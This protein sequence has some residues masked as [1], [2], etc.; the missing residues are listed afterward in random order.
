MKTQRNKYV[1]ALGAALLL[2]TASFT[3]NALPS[4][5]LDIVDGYYDN[6]T[7]TVVTGSNQFSLVAYGV[8]GSI[9]I[10]NEY[11][12]SIAVTPQI[13][14]VLVDFG[15][16]EFGGITYDMNSMVYGTPPVEAAFLQEKDGG[17]LGPHNV[18]PTLFTE[19]EFKFNANQTRSG[20]D[21]QYVTGTDPLLNSG[22][23]LF[24]KLFDVD[25]SN[26]LAG[27]QLHFDLYNTAVKRGG[28]ID[29]DDFAPFSHDAATVTVPE[30]A[31]LVLLGLGMLMLAFTTGRKRLSTQA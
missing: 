25:V 22:S 29:V 10:D 31:P 27:F 1:A 6:S 17:D 12:I 14:P 16:F 24:Y 7:E 11:F 15:S 9:N 21:T 30:P 2:T 3:A 4:L 26:L 20:V 5:Q 13:G 28:D 19:V 23:A 18:Y 8:N